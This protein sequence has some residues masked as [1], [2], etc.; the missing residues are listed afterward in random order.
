VNV[1]LNKLVA[2]GVL[3]GFRTNFGSSAD[4]VGLHVIVGPG[5]G[6]DPEHVRRTVEECLEP[7]VPDTVV[8]VDRSR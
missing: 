8:T 6:S 5:V 2:E 3:T 7:I 4:A 1:A